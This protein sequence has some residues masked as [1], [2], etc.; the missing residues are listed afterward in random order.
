MISLCPPVRG[1]P[2]PDGAIAVAFGAPQ[3]TWARRV[4]RG[5]AEKLAAETQT[6]NWTRRYEVRRLPSLEGLTERWL[7]TDESGVD[8]DIESVQE[9]PMGRR[10]HWWIHAVRREAGQ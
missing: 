3:R 4:D 7:L 2:G 9:A 10:R 5:G 1:A 8:L 6:G